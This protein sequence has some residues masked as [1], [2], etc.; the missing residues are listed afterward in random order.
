MKKAY[1][2]L[3]LILVFSAVHAQG[4][5][6]YSLK[7]CIAYSLEHNPQSTIYKN[8]V[9]ITQQKKKEYTAPYLPNISLKGSFD[10]NFLL[11]ASVI[12][13]DQA[14]AFNPLAPAEK[15]VLRFGAP[16]TSGVILRLDQSVFDQGMLIVR[17]LNQYTEQLNNAT[18]TKGNEEMIYNTI[19]AYY[20]LLTL[21]EQGK[22]LQDNEKKN[23]ELL[24]VLKLRLE[25]GVIQPIDLNRVLVA[26]NNVIS[27]INVNRVNAN[28]A[29]NQLKFAMGMDLKELLLVNDTIDYDEE[30][31]L[32]AEV[33]FKPDA[34]PAYQ[35][36]K[37][38]LQL[39]EIGVKQS[40][41]ALY[42]RLS[43]YADY[44]GLGFGYGNI[45]ET[46]SELFPYS[47]IGLTLN[48]SL[49]D[50][51]KTYS[52]I[53]QSKLGLDNAK[54][55]MKLSVMNYEMNYKNAHSRLISS[56]ENVTN[57]KMNLDLAQE[58]FRNSTLQYEKGVAS[59]S[60]FLNTQYSY[61]ESQVN[62]IT[63]LI[64][65]LTARVDHEKATGNLSAFV[66]KMK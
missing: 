26:Q 23:S 19:N 8:D 33:E 34:L 47:S 30:V 58:V 66:Q 3:L 28:V 2:T 15:I 10:Y 22:L 1:L 4:T 29:L 50:G 20:K 7:N 41:S 61:K 9:K 60:D 12:P 42:P 38:Q 55:N 35:E 27:Q 37:M 45:S 14:R 57:T 13:A 62:Y 17:K 5:V 39:Q 48:I 59:L 43:A 51:G 6:I 31:V 49:F 64:N 46:F 16:Y 11:R 40:K 36:Q 32:P 25:K 53:K 65:Y 52:K 63:A 56:Y 21:R 18:V 44:G 54:Q 24:E